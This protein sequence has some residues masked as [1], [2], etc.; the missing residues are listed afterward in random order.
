MRQ[1]QAPVTYSSTT[2]SGERRAWQ[3]IL[4]GSLAARAREVIQAIAR[5]LCVLPPRRFAAE[6]LAAEAS[7]FGGRAGLAVYF[8]EKTERNA[9]PL[10]LCVVK[11]FSSTPLT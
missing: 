1:G 11:M 6:Q 8:A 10:F 9:N 7:L 5:G 3:T 2:P 4:D